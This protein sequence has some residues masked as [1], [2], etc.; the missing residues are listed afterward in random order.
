MPFGNEMPA[1]AIEVERR[2]SISELRELSIR[3]TVAAAGG[4][5]RAWTLVIQRLI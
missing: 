5:R 3:L 4:A 1:V 2:D